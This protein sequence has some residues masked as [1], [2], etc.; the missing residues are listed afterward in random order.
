M[1]SF[2]RVGVDVGGVVLISLA[3]HDS[4]VVVV[5]GC[6]VEGALDS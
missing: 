5:D 1:L 6:S 4:G 3:L 2:G